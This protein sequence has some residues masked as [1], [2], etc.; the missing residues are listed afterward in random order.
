MTNPSEQMTVSG[1]TCKSCP[2]PIEPGER[3]VVFTPKVAYHRACWR[4]IVNPPKPTALERRAG[5]NW[6][7]L[8]RC[9]IP[10]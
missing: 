3:A 7:R 8:G 1:I 5:R 4:L 10:A 9:R 6:P 2:H